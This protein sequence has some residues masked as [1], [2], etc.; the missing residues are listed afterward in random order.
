MDLSLVLINF[1]WRQSI[2]VKENRKNACF[3]VVRAK[4]KLLSLYTFLKKKINY[5]F[6]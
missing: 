6:L 3:V 4:L 5:F 1:N 2:V